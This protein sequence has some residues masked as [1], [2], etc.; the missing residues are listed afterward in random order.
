MSVSSDFDREFG[1][2]RSSLHT[3]HRTS[4]QSMRLWL[5]LKRMALAHPPRFDDIVRPY[6]ATHLK[7]A[8][9]L[10]LLRD[11]DELMW[12]WDVM[13][14]VPLGFRSDHRCLSDETL[15]RLLSHPA[16]DAVHK[17]SLGPHEVGALT[18]ETVR[19]SLYIQHLCDLDVRDAPQAN[20]FLERLLARE[21]LTLC[22]LTLDGCQVS[23]DVME[24]LLDRLPCRVC[25]IWYGFNVK[26]LFEDTVDS[27]RSFHSQFHGIEEVR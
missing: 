5:H 25:V 15:A 22:H 6:L 10:A 26:Y 1:V 2:L 24:L 4:G 3:E 21:N 7:D 17:L 18:L 14:E 8:E 20:A 13:P 9:R 12:A 23:Q 16:V 19:S 11:P 27:V